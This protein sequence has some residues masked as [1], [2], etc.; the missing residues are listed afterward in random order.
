M[1]A[2]FY[3]EVKAIAHFDLS[4]NDGKKIAQMRG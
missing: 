2:I 4:Q 1:T 3:A